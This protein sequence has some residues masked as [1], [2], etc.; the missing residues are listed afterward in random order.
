[1]RTRGIRVY[2]FTTQNIVPV[3][4]YPPLKQNLKFLRKNYNNH[5]LIIWRITSKLF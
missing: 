1:M 3:T 5:L 4:V 2:E